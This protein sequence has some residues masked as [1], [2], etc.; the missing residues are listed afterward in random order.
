MEMNENQFPA[1]EAVTVHRDTSE[2]ENQFAN[3]AEFKVPSYQKSHS[4]P[5]NDQE[6]T[7]RHRSNRRSHRGSSS[8]I[9]NR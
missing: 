1:P 5:D 9:L 8:I 4:H 2:I 7:N 6:P 3:I